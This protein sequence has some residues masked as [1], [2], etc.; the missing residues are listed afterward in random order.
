MARRDRASDTIV[1]I[2]AHRCT[3]R[4]D[5]TVRNAVGDVIQFLYGEDGMDGAAIEGQ[6]LEHLRMTP[7][8]FRSTFRIDLA[9]TGY[10]PPWLKAEDAEQLRSN[11]AAHELLDA[12]YQVQLLTQASRLSVKS[13][14][15]RPRRFAFTCVCCLTAIC[16]VVKACSVA[17]R[18]VLKSGRFRSNWRT[19]CTS[20]K[21]RSCPRGSQA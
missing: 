18:H 5:G 15:E 11:V 20:C 19:T 16:S 8:Q 13:M 2:T 21:R 9:N 4:Y 3:C 10:T 17:R 1:T 7:A 6:K 14:N 12:E